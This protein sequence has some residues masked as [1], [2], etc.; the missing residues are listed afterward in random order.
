MADLI[1]WF[2]TGTQHLNGTWTRN[3][4][5]SALLLTF[6]LLL[7]WFLA[8]HVRNSAIS[9][10]ELRRRWLVQVRNGCFLL[11]MLGLVVI[12]SQELEKLAISLLAIVV[13]IVLATKELILCLTGSLLKMRA[14]SFSV[15]DRIEVNGLRGDVVDQT[16]LTTRLAELKPVGGALQY[17]GRSITLPNSL[18]LSFAVSNDSELDQFILH[19]VVVPLARADNNWQAAESALMAAANAVSAPYLDEARQHID[20]HARKQGLETTAVEPRIALSFPDPARIDLTL[21]V[22]APARQGRRIEQEILRRYLDTMDTGAKS[23][24]AVSDAPAD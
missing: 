16:L 5:A 11:L 10:P 15:G 24:A 4:I 23:A 6:V 21:R 20:R 7:R 9:S 12:W 1:G 14:G 3:I 13:A 8:H 19:S 18:F 22:S 2:S 17:T